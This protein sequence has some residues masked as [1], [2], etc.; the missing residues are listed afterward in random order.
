MKGDDNLEKI[1]SF[2]YRY[3]KGIIMSLIVIIFL[4]LLAA[5]IFFITLDD[6]TYKDGDMSSTPYAAST[7]TKSVKFTENGL[8]FIYKY[9]DE[10][11]G[12]EVE[13]EKTPKEMAQITWDEMIKSGSTVTNY[14][15]TVDELEKLMNAEVITQYPKLD[16]NVELNG[17]IEFE[18]HK[19]DGTSIKLKYIDLDTFN[20]YITD[21]NI[22]VVNYYTLDESENVLIGVVDETTETLTSNDSEMNLSDYSET[23]TSSNS[24]GS[25]EYSRTEYDVYSKPINYKSVVSKYTMP[26][27]YLWSLIVIGDDKG[28]GLELADLVDQSEIVISVYD[29]ITTTVDT[30]VTTYK[31]EKKVNVSATATATK[32][33]A[34]I[35]SKSD[36]WNPANEWE[37]DT[38]YKITHITTYKNNTPI[39]D[40][41]KA[42][43]W[44]VNYSKNY[45]LGPK[46]VTKEENSRNLEDT[47]YVGEKEN[48][49]ISSSGTDLP[50]YVK[51][52]DKLSELVNGLESSLKSY[53]NTSINNSTNSTTSSVSVSITSCSA[54][55]FKRNINIKEKDETIITTQSYVADTPVNEPKV[56]KKT[57]EEIRNGTGQNNFVT[58]L[59]DENHSYARNRITSEITDWLFDLLEN[60]PDTVNMVDLTKFL[61]YKVTG[62]DYGVKD[63]NFDEY[64]NSDFEDTTT[65][66]GSTFEEKV[67]FALTG[68]GYSEY[69]AAGAMGN[70]K[71]E[72]GFKANNLQDSFEGKLGMTDES[73]TTAVNNGTYKNF[74]HDSAGYGL[75]QWTFWSVKQGLYNYT[76]A[77]GVGIDDEDGQI[78][79]LLK[80]IKEGSCTNWKNAKS[81]EDA[82]YWFEKEYEKAG[83]PQMAN[84]LKYAQELYNKYHGKTAPVD[85]DVKLTGDNKTKM[86]ALLKEAQRIANDDRY[87][88]SQSNRYGEYQY[89]CSSLVARLYYKFFG[90]VTPNSTPAYDTK[91]RV[92]ST[93]SVSLQPGDVLWRKGHVTIYIGNGVYVAAH[94]CQG[95]L[96][97]NPAAQISVY[98][99]S[100][101]KYTYVYRF[102]TK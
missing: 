45:N 16:K 95:K 4:I 85:A 58:I 86:E 62:N 63:Y 66:Y 11:T 93:S 84:R 75:A 46:S 101:S 55:Y 52:R 12:E 92:G 68:A 9:K 59:C 83:K 57:D 13:E 34:Y 54:S 47:D 100:P 49:I 99:D 25:G 43:V 64:E 7:Y 82:C 15:D 41:T 98:N 37:D 8:I 14:L 20:K 89:D 39:V 2:L 22:D 27:Q 51:F 28:V 73:Y 77:N 90:I 21:K 102:I 74:I 50:Y 53:S 48:P 78:G 42:D 88:Y 5:F 67:W 33:G 76:K 81:V 18:R 65:I 38:N 10:K 72:S 61:L 19:S 56:E 70:F 69:S 35:K 40:V 97:S 71:Q 1:R 60:N 91:Y 80:S 24:T 30:N 29:N 6:G 36:S 94:G 26:F 79:Y 44:I 23:L 32:N 96:A 31:K 3:R 17:T 87:T